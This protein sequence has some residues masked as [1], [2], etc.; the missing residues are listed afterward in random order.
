MRLSRLVIL[1]T[2]HTDRRA[3]FT[4]KET[5]LRYPDLVSED[6]LPFVRASGST[7]VI[8]SATN[9]TQGTSNLPATKLCS[10]HHQRIHR[11]LQP[12]LP[13]KTKRH[14]RRKCKNSTSPSSNPNPNPQLCSKIARWTTTNAPTP[15][16]PIS[17]ST[18]GS[19]NTPPRF[20]RD[21]TPSHQVRT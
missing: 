3:K 7:R 20:P 15:V 12:H 5:F 18:P 4:G 19:T 1:H 13:P 16:P 6:N 8:D 9:W 17:P 14:P 2:S 11:S 21:S 10:H